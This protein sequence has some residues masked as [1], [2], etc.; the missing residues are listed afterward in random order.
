MPSAGVEKATV[1]PTA[2]GPG[3]SGGRSGGS[4]VPSSHAAV[5]R[6]AES[7]PVSVTASP[8]RS[9]TWIEPASDAPLECH[10][11]TPA[12]ATVT[13]GTLERPPVTTS[14]PVFVTVTLRDSVAPGGTGARGGATETASGASAAS[15]RGTTVAPQRSTDSGAASR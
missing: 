2:Y 5:Q 10:A 15:A 8:G 11:T 9:E 1:A 13:V 4:P 7:T 3:A 6:S 12:S 14:E